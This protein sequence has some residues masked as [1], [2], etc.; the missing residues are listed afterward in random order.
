VKLSRCYRGAHRSVKDCRHLP[1]E[2]FKVSANQGRLRT[3]SRPFRLHHNCRLNRGSR[4]LFVRGLNT[5]LYVPVLAL[6]VYFLLACKLK[7]RRR[8]TTKVLFRGV[9][10]SDEPIAC[11]AVRREQFVE[12]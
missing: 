12:L 10:D 5:A 4:A 2:T 3:I 8:N 11:R 1:R 7:V 9:L 6:G